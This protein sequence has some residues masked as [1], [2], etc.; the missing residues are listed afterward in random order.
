MTFLRNRKINLSIFSFVLFCCAILFFANNALAQSF[1]NQ[2]TYPQPTGPIFSCPDGRQFYFNFSSNSQWEAQVVCF[3]WGPCFPGDF[4]CPAGTNYTVGNNRAF[5]PSIRSYIDADSVCGCDQLFYNGFNW[6]IS[7]C[8]WPDY[9]KSC[10]FWKTLKGQCYDVSGNLLAETYC[11]KCYRTDIFSYETSFANCGDVCVENASLYMYSCGRVVD[12]SNCSGYVPPSCKTEGQ[13]CNSTPDCCSGLACVGGV[14][15]RSCDIR[16]LSCPANCTYGQTVNITYE[17]RNLVPAT[18]PYLYRKGLYSNILGTLSQFFCQANQQVNDNA[19][20][21]ETKTLTCNDLGGGMGNVRVGCKADSASRAD[22][23]FASDVERSCTIVAIPP[24]VPTLSHSGNTLNSITWSWTQ[25]G[26][27][28]TE[29]RLYD[30]SG[31]LV[32]DSITCAGGVGSA[33]SYQE[34]GLSVNTQYSRKLKACNPLG[35]SDF[36]NIASAF[37]SVEAVASASCT[38]LGLD[39]ITVTVSSAGG[40]AFSN[41]TAGSSG[42]KFQRGAEV[43]V[44]AQTRSYTFNGLASNTNY[45][46]TIGPSRNGDA[47]EAAGTASVSCTTAQFVSEP[48]NLR[49]I[50]RTG[51]SITWQWDPVAGAEYYKIYIHDAVAGWLCLKESNFLS[52]TFQQVLA[53]Y[54]GCGICA[55]GCI[56]TLNENSFYGLSV[57]ACNAAMC[58]GYTYASAATLIENPIDILFQATS[59]TLLLTTISWR[60]NYFTNLTKGASGIQFREINTGRIKNFAASTTWSL[61]GL[62][63]NTTYTFFS[64]SRNQE[65]IA[66]TEYGPESYTTPPLPPTNL[67]TVAKGRGIMTDPNDPEF[68]YIDWQWDASQGADS[69]K[70]TYPGNYGSCPT[71]EIA[72]GTSFRQF[73]FCSGTNLGTASFR[74]IDPNHWDKVQIGISACKAGICSEVVKKETVAPIE[75]PDLISCINA[76]NNA[77]DVNVKSNEGKSTYPPFARTRFAFSRLNSGNSGIRI[78]IRNT[79]GSIINSGYNSN[80]VN[81]GTIFTY[82]LGFNYDVQEFLPANWQVTGLQAGTSYQVCAQTRN[83]LADLVVGKIFYPAGPYDY[84]PGPDSGQWNCV[85]CSTAGLTAVGNIRVQAPTGIIKLKLISISDALSLLRGMIKV[86]LPSGEAAAELVDVADPDASPV[87]VQTPTGIKAWRIAPIW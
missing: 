60:G 81:T 64:Q 3:P 44:W 32:K 38:A 17:Y 11:R 75:T 12:D 78:Q 54:I 69:Y 52:T 9:S 45:T 20:H 57:S 13:S 87:R 28:P 65:G 15:V 34:T 19:W 68:W 71:T 36:S 37:T 84:R 48:K 82:N 5:Y 47:E 8:G 67:R 25:V 2:V 70:I 55:G 74:F 7:D 35:S 4:Q 58:S 53:P 6:S 14:C 83:W 41:L 63:P 29:Y 30:S 21:Q 66:G 62:L 85:T 73:H 61:T 27:S 16:N 42:I 33:C 18:K 59:Q 23:A 1:C 76:Q 40:G 39:F 46:F 22:C 79:D 43:P 56:Q 24:N 50:A 26:N 49:P 10:T 80:W 51:T 86:Q 31:G 72:S 77:F